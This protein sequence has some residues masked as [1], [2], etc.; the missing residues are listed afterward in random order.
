MQFSITQNLFKKILFIVHCFDENTV[1][2][3][4]R[5][6]KRFKKCLNTVLHGCHDQAQKSRNRQIFRWFTQLNFYNAPTQRQKELAAIECYTSQVYVSAN[7]PRDKKYW[8][9]VEADCNTKFSLIT[10]K[11]HGNTYVEYH[12]DLVRGWKDKVN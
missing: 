4:F 12:F 11:I 5:F 2:H 1:K 3:E 7:G 8:L 10:E 9:L 6:K